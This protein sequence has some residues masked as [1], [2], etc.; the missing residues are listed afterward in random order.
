MHFT[1]MTILAACLA[2]MP[3]SAEI[4]SA[5]ACAPAIAEDAAK[6]REEAALWVRTGGGVPARICEAAALEALGA[7]ATAALL[8]G[9][10]AAERNTVMAA[11]LRATIFADAAGLWREAGRPDLARAALAAADRLVAPDAGSL[12]ARAR[13]EAEGGDWAAADASLAAALALS[14]DDAEILALRAATLRHTGAV[15]DALATARKA[16]ARAP[17]LAEAQFEEAA[18]VAESGD[19]LAAI[20][21]WQGL[22]AD[23][24]GTPLAE[25]AARNLQRARTEDPVTPATAAE[26]V[27]RP[28]PPRLAPPDQDRVP[29]PLPRP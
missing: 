10:L 11:D 17:D 29:A 13:A 2:A 24:P 28:K 26:A 12:T 6:A 4:R 14:P 20:P 27:P 15:D 18:A 19:A 3:A 5:G 25:A 9:T 22:I 1:R 16:R 23:H 21:L 8:L 7:L